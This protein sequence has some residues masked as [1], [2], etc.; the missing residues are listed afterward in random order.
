MEASASN[1]AA[2]VAISTNISL[3]GWT[4][5]GVL[6]ETALGAEGMLVVTNFAVP[7]GNYAVRITGLS[8][9]FRVIGTGVIQT[10]CTLPIF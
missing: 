5:L 1:G 8:G 4:T 10:N 7:L 6:D 9:L 2:S 3:P